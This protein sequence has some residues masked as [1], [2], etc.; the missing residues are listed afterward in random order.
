MSVTNELPRDVF[1]DCVHQAAKR[2]KNIYFLSADLGAKALDRFRAEMNGQFIHAGICEQNMIDVA[3]GLALEGKIVY[4]Y[5]MAPFVTLRCY[6]Q[7]K[8]ALASMALPVTIIGVGVGYSYDD[9]G[10]THYATEDLS[11]MRAL[12]GIEIVTPCDTQSVMVTAHATYTQPALRYVRLDRVFLP[13]VYLPNDTRFLADGMVEIE[14]G[15]QVCLITTGYMVHKALEVSKVL[16]AAGY[17]VGVVDLY[18]IKPI[19]VSVLRAVVER[20]ERIVTLE[21]HFL[22]G[23]LGSAVLEAC[24]DAGIS[25][26]FLRL[27]I[28]D[29]Y[30]FENGGRDYLHR[31]VGL[32]VPSLTARIAEFLSRTE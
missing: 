22:S 25:R 27:G 28:P 31:L 19:D 23:G 4:V 6:E 15:D 1:I 18:R 21:E 11:C 20:Y 16:Q 8:V 2:D 29:Q 5:A 24:A 9:A 14:R 30:R 32:D 26:P 12:G 13:S 10:P 3:A 7:I 17:R